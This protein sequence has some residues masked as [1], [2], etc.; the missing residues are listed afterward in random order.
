ML[1]IACIYSFQES[2]WVSCQKIVVNLRQ[3]YGTLQDYEIQNFNFSITCSEFDVQEMA[4]DVAEYRPDFLVIIDHKPHPLNFIAHLIP[5][6]PLNKTKILFHIFGDFTLYYHQWEKLGTLLK[7]YEVKFIVASER[8]K[9]LIDRF[10]NAENECSV[11]HFPVHKKEFNF[12]PSLRSKQRL[13]WNIDDNDLA[14][15]FTGRLSR[16]KRIHTLIELFA[17]CLEMKNKQKIHLYLYGL[18]DHIGDPFLNK[19][20]IEGEYFRKIYKLFLKLPEESRPFIH[21]MGHLPNVELQTTYHGADFL[22]NLSVHNDEDFGMSVAEAQCC[23]LPAILT[24]W[25]GLAG[26]ERSEIEGAT[27]FIPVKIGERSKILSKNAVREA[28]TTILSGK[29]IINRSDLSKIALRELSIEAAGE[30]LQNTLNAPWEKFLGFS[31]FFNKVLDTMTFNTMPYM[32]RNNKI[33]N[34]YKEIYSAYV[35]NN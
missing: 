19:W 7:G 24:D 29:T 12:T 6:L 30:R 8:Q 20:E 16:Q 10:L 1:K 26:F 2:S 35:R 4:K 13:E 5:L 14:F 33:N 18:P 31:L 15:V 23:G 17:E 25:G 32:N 11:C 21:F 34:M 22:I 28:F 3:A 27:Y 9:I